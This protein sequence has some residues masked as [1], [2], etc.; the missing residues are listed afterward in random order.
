MNREARN[1]LIATALLVTLLGFFIVSI[2]AGWLVGAPMAACGILLTLG[3]LVL[4]GWYSS[5]AGDGLV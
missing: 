3:Y 4:A 2:S 5:L 1:Y